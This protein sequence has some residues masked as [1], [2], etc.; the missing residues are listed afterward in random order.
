MIC[1]WGPGR[2]QA[3]QVAN[4]EVQRRRDAQMRLGE[5][6]TNVDDIFDY[7]HDEILSLRLKPGENKKIINR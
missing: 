3:Q 1:V 4:M 2:C 5:H 6:R 7:L